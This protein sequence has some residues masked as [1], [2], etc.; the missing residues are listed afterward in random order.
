MKMAM[1]TFI[2]VEFVFSFLTS[3]R[4]MLEIIWSRNIFQTVLLTLVHF[5]MLCWALEKH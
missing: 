3:H 4:G 2:N 1:D 5:V